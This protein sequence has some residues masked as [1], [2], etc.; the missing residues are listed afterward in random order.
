M[1]EAAEIERETTN[2]DAPFVRPDVAMMKW[3]SLT[4]AKP[5]G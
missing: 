1:T 3:C 4:R 5:I 2:A